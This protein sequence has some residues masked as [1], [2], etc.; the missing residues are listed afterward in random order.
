M[1]AAD[2]MLCR[3][4]AT[5][6]W[7]TAPAPDATLHCKPPEEGRQVCNEDTVASMWPAAVSDLLAFLGGRFRS[8]SRAASIY[9][10]MTSTGYAATF[11]QVSAENTGAL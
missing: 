10:C 3:G 8:P 4:L 1:H 2:F 5:D 9:V 11:A 6:G 7:G